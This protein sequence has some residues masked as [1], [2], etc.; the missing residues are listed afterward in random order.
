MYLIS[1]REYKKFTVIRV[2]LSI[3]RGDNEEHPYD[4]DNLYL[5]LNNIGYDNII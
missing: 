4:E 5:E 3:V 2:N 1:E